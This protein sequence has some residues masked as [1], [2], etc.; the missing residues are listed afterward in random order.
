M[1]VAQVELITELDELERRAGASL[2]RAGQV[3]LFDRLSWWKLTERHI[4][5]TAP[6]VVEARSEGAMLWLP[7][8]RAGGRLQPL[9]SWYTLKYA[10]VTNGTQ[11]HEEALLASA[12]ARLR[13]VAP[14]VMLWPLTEQV[15]ERV[16]AGFRNAGW[17]V[18]SAETSANWRAD[19]STG[20]TVYWAARP[21]RLR[22][23]SERKARRSGLAISLHTCEDDALWA[24]FQAVFRASWKPD[25]GSG[26]FL[27]DLARQEAAAD[28]LRISVARSNGVAVAA[29]LWT[30]EHGVATLHKLAQRT[31]A[32]RL[33]PGTQLTAW[34]IRQL[35]ERDRVQELD[36][37]TGDDPYKADWAEQRHPLFTLEAADGL[38]L[39][40]AAAA[41]RWRLAALVRRRPLL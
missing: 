6:L 22:N 28:T 29:Q 34:T 40:G 12:A 15:L 18:R 9:G 31:D 3:S 16:S 17:I 33:S 26:D 30:A 21:A 14:V 35:I 5:G 13:G 19:V 2:S 36:F 37:G 25:E 41:V 10:P 27:R 7:L 23:T 11:T 4:S 39:R 24:D 32:D 20:W 38:T 1:D 8:S